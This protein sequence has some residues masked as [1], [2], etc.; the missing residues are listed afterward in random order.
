MLIRCFDTLRDNKFT[1]WVNFLVRLD[2][3][4]KSFCNTPSTSTSASASTF[5]LNFLNG[6]YFLNPL[7]GLVHIWY[8]NRF[9]S[10]IH[11]HGL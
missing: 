3:V 7:M 4:Q 6:L 1:V 11:C 2:E 9:W 8:D 10:N 5:T